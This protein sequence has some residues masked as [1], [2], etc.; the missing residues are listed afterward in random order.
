MVPSDSLD[1]LV[2]TSNQET[3]TDLYPNVGCLFVN[4][5]VLCFA[6]S[7]ARF[8]PFH[9][10]MQDAPLGN[11]SQAV[12]AVTPHFFNVSLAVVTLRPTLRNRISNGLP[13]NQAIFKD[14]IGVRVS[15]SKTRCLG[16]R[17]IKQQRWWCAE[18]F[19]SKPGKGKE[20]THL[21]SRSYASHLAAFST[22]LEQASNCCL[23]PLSPP[24]SIHSM[25][26]IS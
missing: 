12:T 10:Q 18:C 15:G 7:Y 23:L 26:L 13:T 9:D 14:W 1:Q 6:V 4:W 2:C 5:L 20:T 22:H 24:A 25:T 21:A 8:P 3:A 17:A 16:G 11:D 19:S